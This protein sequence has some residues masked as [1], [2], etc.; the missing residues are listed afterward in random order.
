MMMHR[1]RCLLMVTTAVV[2]GT[3]SAFAPITVTNV[4]NTAPVN[5]TPLYA[6]IRERF[7]GS[8]KRRK[9]NDRLVPYHKEI[10]QRQV[11]DLFHAWN[12]ALG[13]GQSKLVAKTYAN[14]AVLIPTSLNEPRVGSASIQE[15]FENVVK[16]KPSVAIVDGTITTGHDWAMNVGIYEWSFGD[17]GS[18]KQA[19]FTFVYVYNEDIKKWMIKHHHSSALPKG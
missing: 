3:T 6:G 17:D 16:R 11:V 4:R 7:F 10:A 13:T 19:R 9:R 14:D 12:D 8:I 5:I 18:K 2:A 15:Y 1:N